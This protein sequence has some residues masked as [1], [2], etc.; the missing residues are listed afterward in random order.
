M[1][2][3][4]DYIR[5]DEAAALLGMTPKALNRL[6]E[7]RGWPSERVGRFS[8]YRR[9]DVEPEAARRLAMARRITP[10]DRAIAARCARLVKDY[11]AKRGFTLD[12]EVVGVELVSDTRNGWPVRRR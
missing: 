9:A 8:A 2:N 1:T 6:A 11:W 3:D 5:S 4:A 10:A 12:V 7:R